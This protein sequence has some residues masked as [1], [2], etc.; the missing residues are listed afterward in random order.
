M[1]KRVLIVD[2]SRLARMAVIKG[3]G[4]L[5]P[6]WTYVEA[7]NPDE[8]VA[9]MRASA[10]DVAVIDFNMPVRDG[11]A[12]AGELRE[13]HPDLPIALLSA[14]A[15][16]EILNRTAQLGATFLTKPL[17]TAAFGAFLD[18]ATQQ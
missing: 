7:A 9:S 6:G 14:N 16:E 12:L 1:T 13:L 18:T 8:A 15:Q 11:L 4:Q 10:A 17:N 2:D 5:R 3:L